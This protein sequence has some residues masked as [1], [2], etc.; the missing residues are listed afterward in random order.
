MRTVGE[1]LREG[2][3]QWQG[4]D[5]A[6]GEAFGSREV[7]LL[8]AHQLGWTEAQVL[9]RDDV[10]VEP[11]VERR[12]FQHLARRLAGEPFAYLVGEREFFGRR[13]RVDGRALIPRPETEHL[14]EACLGLDLPP[15]ALVVDV[16][17]GSGCIALTLALE[18][19]SWRVVA[20]DRSPAAAVVAET[21]RRRMGATALVGAGDLTGALRPEAIDL[22]VSNPPYVP[23]TDRRKLSRDILDH[24]PHEALFAAENGLAV[25]R[26]LFTELGALRSGSALALEVGDGQ[27]EAVT[28]LGTRL[29]FS[30]EAP[31]RDFSGVDRVVIGRR[32]AAVAAPG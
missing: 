5:G 6:S 30:F 15:R 12:Y 4:L 1:I 8:L 27:A 28:R 14:V 17:T 20:L 3:D 11:A 2:R 16:G 29:G 24:E 21:N 26:R 25:Y 10:A 23:P 13:F 9:S 18:R 22:V 31:I 32:A 7:S 19:P